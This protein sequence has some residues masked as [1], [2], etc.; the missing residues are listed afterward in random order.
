ME[1]KDGSSDGIE[2]GQHDG[3]ISMIFCYYLSYEV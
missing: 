3:L 2:S 1:A